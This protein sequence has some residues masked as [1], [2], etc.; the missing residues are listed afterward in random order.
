MSR[1]A[2][3]LGSALMTMRCLPRCAYA[4]SPPGWVA[5]AAGPARTS[6]G[7]CCPPGWAALS[8]KYALRWWAPRWLPWRASPAAFA[9]A[10]HRRADPHTAACCTAARCCAGAL[11]HCICQAHW[12]HDRH[13]GETASAACLQVPRSV[14]AD[15]VQEAVDKLGSCTPDAA[16]Q[17]LVWTGFA[18]MLFNACIAHP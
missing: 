7:S 13:F 16:P 10:S 5:T 17:V 6:C 9:M 3:R 12:R 4:S 11:M 2:W 8:R 14:C 15:L 18:L 1:R